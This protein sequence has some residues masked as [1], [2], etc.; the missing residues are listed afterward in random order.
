[1][2]A[3]GVGILI[4]YILVKYMFHKQTEHTIKTASE[5]FDD[6]NESLSKNL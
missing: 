3:E 4:I 5:I 6:I 1:M 2:N